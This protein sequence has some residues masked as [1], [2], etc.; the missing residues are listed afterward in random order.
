MAGGSFCHE[1]LAC[2]RPDRSK[3]FTTYLLLQMD[4]WA[5]QSGLQNTL[6]FSLF[7]QALFE[8]NTLSPD[9]GM[10]EKPLLQLLSLN[11]E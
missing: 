7:R 4:L 11:T 9:P 5:A 3:D 8:L 6:A 10:K 1:F 2:S